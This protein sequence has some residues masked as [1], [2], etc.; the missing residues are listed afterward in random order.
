MKKVGGEDPSS[1]CLAQVALRAT[2]RV[3]LA[4]GALERLKGWGLHRVKRMGRG[5]RGGLAC[6]G[7]EGAM[8]RAA[9]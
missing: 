5:V 2:P 4:A 9:A 7:G 1:T 3:F 6:R 8:R